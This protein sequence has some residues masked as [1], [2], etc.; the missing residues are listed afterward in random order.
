M[1]DLIHDLYGNRVRVRACGICIQEGK[2]LLVN[3]RSIS[4]ADFWA[5]PGG[6]ISI[7]ETA[8]SCISREFQEETGLSVSVGQFLFAGEFVNPPLHAI[9]LFFEVS[10]LGGTLVVGRDPEM[11]NQ[12][13]IIQEVRFLSEA[14]IKSMKSSA[15][16]GLFQIATDPG[17]ILHLKGYFKL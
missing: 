13:Q 9:E 4:E 12:A 16:H 1:Q 14:E 11:D 8:M 7:G 5:P 17:K 2:L 6:G 10:I 3:H 15:L